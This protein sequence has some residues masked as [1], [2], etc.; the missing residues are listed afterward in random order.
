MRKYPKI[1]T[2][3]YLE[4]LVAEAEAEEK[5]IKILKCNQYSNSLYNSVQYDNDTL[6]NQD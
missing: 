3:Q 4:K 1:I 2:L 6:N 5:Q